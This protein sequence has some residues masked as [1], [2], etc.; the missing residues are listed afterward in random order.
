MIVNL[1]KC[2]HHNIYE[3]I[4]SKENVLSTLYLVNLGVTK[5]SVDKKP[6]LNIAKKKTNKK[7]KVW[8]FGFRIRNLKKDG[9]EL[10][11]LKCVLLCYKETDTLPT[12]L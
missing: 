4:L 9:T 7:E 5:S 11:L 3:M 12:T 10:G 2:I 6:K 8:T 1:L